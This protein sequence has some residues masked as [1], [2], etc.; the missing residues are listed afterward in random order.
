MD[1]DTESDH[2]YTTQW[3]D[4]DVTVT[5]GSKKKKFDKDAKLER[6]V[7]ELKEQHGQLYTP[8]QYRFWGEMINGGLHSS[9]TESPD[10]SMFLRAGGKQPKRKSEVAEALTEVAKHT[11]AA[12]SGAIPTNSTNTAGASPRK[13]IENR[14]KCY[15]QLSDL[16]DLRSNGVLHDRGRISV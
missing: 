11:S 10:S 6:L 4:E 15:K 16:N 3:S 2:R 9:K 8:M 5:S 12:F 14:S 1:S 7:S 13:S